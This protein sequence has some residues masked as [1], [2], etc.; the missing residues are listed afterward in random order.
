MNYTTPIVILAVIVI[1][2]AI[3]FI[4][5]KKEMFQVN[6]YPFTQKED[7]KPL[8][9]LYLNTDYGHISAHVTP[10]NILKITANLPLPDGGDY[11]NTQKKYYVFLEKEKLGE[12][13]REQD[14]YFYFFKSLGDK[15]FQIKEIKIVS[16]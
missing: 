13:K 12:L 2:A 4:A 6:V 7:S 14:G 3:I 10:A 9:T 1:V 11:N 8:E 5:S 15:K 16:E